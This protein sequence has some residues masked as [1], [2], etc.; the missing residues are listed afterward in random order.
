[1]VRQS[2]TRGRSQPTPIISRLRLLMAI[3]VLGLSTSTTG[4]YQTPGYVCY[5]TFVQN[6]GCA[7]KIGCS[8][9]ITAYCEYPHTYNWC[10]ADTWFH[11]C[12][13]QLTASCGRQI[14][15]I[16]DLPND[17]YCDD[18]SFCGECF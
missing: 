7:E 5:D 8:G 11:C 1:M 3:I 9:S 14:D 4:Q 6:P 17:D 13:I 12:R 2:M 16:S 15:C 18:I 10:N